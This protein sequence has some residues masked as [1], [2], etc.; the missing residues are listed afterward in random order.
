MGTFKHATILYGKDIRNKQII[1]DTHLRFSGNSTN[2][3]RSETS[4]RTIKSPRSYMERNIRNK[5]IVQDTH[6]RFSGNSTNSERSETSNRTIKSGSSYVDVQ[7]VQNRDGQPRSYMERNIRN[8]VKQIVQD[9]HLRFSGNSTN[10]ERSETSHRT[11]Q[12]GSSYV[13]VQHWQNRDGQGRLQDIEEFNEFPKDYDDDIEENENVHGTEHFRISNHSRGSN[14]TKQSGSSYGEVQGVQNRDGQATGIQQ[15]SY[16]PLGP[17]LIHV[18][19]SPLNLQLQNDTEA[20]RAVLHYNGRQ[21]EHYDNSRSRY[22]RRDRYA[23]ISD[24]TPYYAD[25]GPRSL[26][27]ITSRE[28]PP[29]LP[30]ARPTYCVLEPGLVHRDTERDQSEPKHKSCSIKRACQCAIW[31]AIF[32]GISIGVALSTFNNM[33]AN[34]LEEKII[35]GNNQIN[36]TL[37]SSLKTFSDSFNE[38]IV[39]VQNVSHTLWDET[40]NLRNQTETSLRELRRKSLELSEELK[41]FNDSFDAAII[42]VKNDSQTLRNKISGLRNETQTSI[43][44]LKTMPLEVFEKLK[45]FEDLFNEATESVRN[46]SQTLRNEISNIRNRTETSIQELK[47]EMSELFEEFKRNMTAYY[48]N[49]TGYQ[50]SGSRS[51]SGGQCYNSTTKGCVDQ[52]DSMCEGDYQSCSTC[53]G[54]V[55]CAHRILHQRDCSSG[56]DLHL[57]WD[58]NTKTCESV[59][60]TCQ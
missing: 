9:T 6:L 36:H 4:N 56:S 43:Q 10:Y 54:Y 42:S 2:S 53:N 20:D 11:I 35:E 52:C 15:L 8:I 48:T 57:V 24:N 41:V 14:I 28:Q 44:E 45:T 32:L 34:N 27:S 55:T 5:L 29:P 58:D 12:S 31:T 50:D 3:E 33:N 46:D 30:S 38:T 13:D 47:T 21:R 51:D 18:P 37:A 26:Q 19:L 39:S 25:V 1:Q 22:Q 59:S 40:S 17:R 23:H 60:N 7:H 16:C 49:Q